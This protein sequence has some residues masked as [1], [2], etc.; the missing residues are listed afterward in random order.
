M[1]S[2][3]NRHS[4]RKSLRKTPLWL[5]RGRRE[6]PVSVHTGKKV[7]QASRRLRRNTHTHSLTHTRSL[8]HTHTHTA[9]VALLARC[10]RALVLVHRAAG[11]SRCGEWVALGTRRPPKHN[12]HLHAEG[13]PSHHAPQEN[14]PHVTLKTRLGKTKHRHQSHALDVVVDGAFTQS[15]TVK[16]VASTLLSFAPTS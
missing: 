6:T 16:S 10:R 1:K 2:P 13:C 7:N 3:S 14:N 11:R 5:A 8:T 9:R 15:A 12:S 4:A